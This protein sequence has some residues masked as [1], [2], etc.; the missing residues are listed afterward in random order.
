MILMNKNSECYF[1]EIYSL[2]KKKDYILFENEGAFSF[3]S[4]KPSNFGHSMIVVKKHI[5]SLPKLL[6]PDLNHLFGALEGTYD[7][8][9]EIFISNPG[10][11]MN[12]YHSLVN[13]PP[14]PI[15]KEY[16]IVQIEKGI[17]EDEPQGFNWGMNYGYH[18]GQRVSHL[19]LH[20]FPRLKGLGIATAMQKHLY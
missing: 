15:S 9:K 13:N 4:Y 20:L 19:H 10:K 7:I 12:F 18:A 1:C 17:P 3:L 16:A 5:T 14:E 6:S 8:I 11:I 2:Y